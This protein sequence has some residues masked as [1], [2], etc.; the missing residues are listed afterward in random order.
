[1]TDRSYHGGQT[2]EERLEQLKQRL[3]GRTDRNGESLPGYKDNVEAIRQE[4]DRLEG[5]A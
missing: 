3:A 5:L 4:I 2:R 1:M